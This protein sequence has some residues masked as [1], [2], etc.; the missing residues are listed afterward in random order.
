ME[1]ASGIHR[2]ETLL[3]E[4]L[5]A[6][7]LLTG[8]A[9]MLLIDTGLDDTPR[10][11]VL[12]YLQTI[13]RPPAAID[14]VVITHA[15][16]D[17]MGGN[18][19]LRETAPAAVFLCHELD[20]PWIESTDVLI[21]ANYSQ[22]R[23]DHGIDETADSKAFI[24]AN[25][26]SV[27]V[28]IGVQGGETL[29]LGPAWR[30]ELLHTPGHTR[31]HLSIYDPRSRAAI[32]T[33]TALWHGLVTKAGAPA[34]PPTYRHVDSYLA[35]IQRL[36]GLPIETMLTSHYP[37]LSGPAATA[38][39]AESRAYVER[40]E[41]A[42]RDE[43]RRAQGARTMRQLIEALGPRLGEWPDATY[44]VYPLAGHLDRLVQHRLAVAVRDGDAVAWRWVG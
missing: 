33:D 12:P 8:E 38:F 22:F 11:A 31:G 5:L 27:P 3:G 4:R 15:D 35:S 44:L 24:R 19:A 6:L 43:L 7:Y 42:L 1:V 18:A 17:H 29:Q 25:A 10:D 14:R 2:V 32:I 30:V 16:F 39:L 36:Q 37:V 13:G 41:A 21:E 26:R 20:R 40:V 28:D 9:H 34:F 23:A